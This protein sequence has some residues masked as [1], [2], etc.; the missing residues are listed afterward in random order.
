MWNDVFDLREFYA[1]AKGCMVAR[2]VSQRIR[3]IW[4]DLTGCC[5]LGIGFPAPFLGIYRGEAERVIAAMPAG[6]G[7][8]RWPEGQKNLTVLSDEHMLPFADRSIDRLLL[9]HCLEGSSHLQPLLRECWRVLSDGGRLLVVVANRRGLW[10]QSESSPFALGRPYSAGQITRL[11]KDNLFVPIQTRGFLYALPVGWHFFRTWSVVLERL[12]G[13]IFPAFGGL[14]AVEAEKQIYA[15]PFSGANE[16]T[17]PRGVL[18]RPAGG[19]VR[20]TYF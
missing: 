17:S 19:G 6:Q 16:K 11:L 18:A 5:L 4:P 15:L 3:D 10:A 7:V 1:G 12:G 8:L 2:V 14:L 9:V 13:S 20:R